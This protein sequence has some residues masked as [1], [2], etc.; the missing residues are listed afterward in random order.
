MTAALFA[1][2]LA[3]SGPA[4]KAA[5][6]D[7]LL[8]RLQEPDGSPVGGAEVR[9][10]GRS[11]EELAGGRYR[12]ASA[13]PGRHLLRVVSLGHATRELGL[14]L[15]DSALVA[16]RIVLAVRPV[17]LGG[18]LAEV[19]KPGGG[20]LPAG[21]A[22]SRTRFRESAVPA[23]TLADWLAGQPS[24][25]LR[26]RG[27]GSRQEVTVRGSRPEGVLVLLDGV[28]L[29]DPVTGTADLSMVPVGSLASATLVR[30]TASGRFGSG[31]LGGVLLLRS[32]RPGGTLASGGLETGSF[33]R[34]AADLYGSVSG[35]T[36]ALSL[37]LRR[38]S[39]ENHFRFRDRVLPGSPVER[40]RNAD[41]TA[42]HGALHGSLKG[43]PVRLDLRADRIDRGAPGRM[44]VRLYDAA[45]QSDRRIQGALS[46]GARWTDQLSL[47]F[48]TQTLG[49]RPDPG[50]PA[51]RQRVRSLLLEGRRRRLPGGLGLSG[52]LSLEEVRG[53]GIR[54]SPS[55]A[56]GELGLDRGFEA[57]DWRIVPS[58]GLEAARGRMV[59]S[60][61]LAAELRPAAGLTLWGRAGQG[62]RLPTFADLYFASA[63]RVR[64]DPDLRPERVTLDAELGARL[65]RELAGGS[66]SAEASGFYRRT[67]DPIVWLASSVAVWSPRNLEGLQA[68]GVELGLGWESAGQGWSLELS[69]SWTRSRV[70]FGS[71]RNPLPYQ[72]EIVARTVLERRWG[73]RALRLQERCLGSRTTSLAA[74]HRLAG[75]CLMDLGGRQSLRLAGIAA[76]LRVEVRNALDRR[77]E[78]VELFPEPG[79][80]VE[81]RL[82]LR[83]GGRD[84]SDDRAEA[85]DDR[86]PVETTRGGGEER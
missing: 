19:E 30:G 55:R 50:S 74:T 38:E 31:A 24:V 33:G 86:P 71:N 61:S 42:T 4:G 56:T 36:G 23:A 44:G 20:A 47:G 72:P 40:R 70:G 77:Y 54:G 46:W 80:A 62:L 76:D 66:V 68:A 15:P 49:Y 78:L 64:P 65:R 48:R 85:A 41:V 7:T 82:D 34:K 21:H 22:T 27:P 59:A 58:L 37:A 29:N 14:F 5:P 26:E 52:R 39:A 2:A 43:I 16:R 13:A 17:E 6:A 1:L 28:P 83:P 35:E 81:L 69:G 75:F 18:L 84:R 3:L 67:R 60:P 51:S 45:R 63:Y 57:G 11:A 73:G 9:L 32:R 25:Q 8:V 10:D 12:F 79:R 53:D